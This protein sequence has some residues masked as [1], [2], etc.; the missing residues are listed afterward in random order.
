ME[1]P[2]PHP[3]PPRQ[4]AGNLPPPPRR[5]D[6]AAS[7]A[8]AAGAGVAAAAA[9]ALPGRDDGG[10]GAGVKAAPGRSGK[11][12]PAVADQS[13]DDLPPPVCLAGVPLP[14]LPSP[15]EVD[16]LDVHDASPADTRALPRTHPS[17]SSSCEA[18][19]SK[20]WSG[21]NDVDDLVAVPPDSEDG[22]TA[23]TSD[24]D[25][26]N[27]NRQN[28]GIK[29]PLN[30]FFVYKV[31]AQPH[32]ALAYPGLS[33]RII[34]KMISRDWNNQTDAVKD[35]FAQLA[36]WEKKK[37]YLR[38]PNYKYRPGRKVAKNRQSRKLAEKE[39]RA[40]G[41]KFSDEK[42]ASLSDKTNSCGNSPE[43]SGTTAVS[44]AAAGERGESPSYESNYP[45]AATD[46]VVEGSANR[47]PVRST[48]GI[49]ED[50]PGFASP[51]AVQRWE[52]ESAQ[53]QTLA[54]DDFSSWHRGGENICTDVAT[55]SAATLPRAPVK[56]RRRRGGCASMPH[57]RGSFGEV[58]TDESTT[59]GTSQSG[60]ERDSDL[61]DVMALADEESKT[62]EECD[63]EI[64]E[65]Q[66]RLERL[67]RLKTRKA[68]EKGILKCVPPRTCSSASASS[69]DGE[70]SSEAG[71][72]GATSS[73]SGKREAMHEELIRDLGSIFGLP[74]RDV[75][76]RTS[77]R[78]RKSNAAPRADF[79]PPA[80]QSAPALAS[81]PQDLYV[82]EPRAWNSQ[83]P[84]PI[85]G[86]APDAAVPSST[87]SFRRPFPAYPYS[88]SYES[89][90]GYSY[91]SFPPSIYS[92]SPLEYFPLDYGAAG[93]PFGGQ[94]HWHPQQQ[95]EN[96]Q[97]GWLPARTPPAEK[98]MDVEKSGPFPARD[99]LPGPVPQYLP[100]AS[101]RYLH[102]FPQHRRSDPFLPPP[103]HGATKAI[104]VSTDSATA[105]SEFD[106]RRHPFA[107]SYAVGVHPHRDDLRT[108][109]T[110]FT[111]MPVR[112]PY[113]Q[114]T[115]GDA[116][117]QPTL[118]VS[119][120]SRPPQAVRPAPVPQVPP[121]SLQQHHHPQPA[122]VAGAR[123]AESD[124]SAAD[125]LGPPPAPSD[126]F[127]ASGKFCG[128]RQEPRGA[129]RG[130]SAAAGEEAPVS[131]ENRQLP[132]F[133]PP[134]AADDQA[135]KSWQSSYHPQAGQ[136]HHSP[137]PLAGS[138]AGTAYRAGPYP[139]D[140]RYQYRRRGDHH[141]HGQ[142]PFSRD[143]RLPADGGIGGPVPVAPAFPA[144]DGP[145][146]ENVPP[147]APTGEFSH[148]IS[149][150]QKAIVPADEDT[151]SDR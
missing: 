76:R 146:Q 83:G 40:A 24:H 39:I 47:A 88:G 103:P 132:S 128:A 52:G 145:P 122:H 60:Y 94:V 101:G 104:S 44:V 62:V 7:P 74:S 15:E 22:L 117:A 131:L 136:L 92:H 38:Y 143:A 109:R 68:N 102:P 64:A 87:Y 149:L 30:R 9:A 23:D 19:G 6:A 41:A 34:S 137:L 4:C 107:S 71:E 85:P 63:E 42:L 91:C 14:P 115:L 1:G 125:Q 134:T 111:E 119:Q 2:L 32:Y 57:H 51:R 139:D 67:K 3:S 150:L 82:V 81:D 70:I 13:K 50:R 105:G 106:T 46:A 75:S 141:A 69:Q 73:Q 133:H 12:G 66:E 135:F 59:S 18:A 97:V 129:P 31:W 84:S 126:D 29:R 55:N 144:V 37:H 35:H 49:E 21:G 140:N 138:A 25:D 16:H 120:N 53:R 113:L 89:D 78:K 80:P 27:D 112:D 127:D 148:A 65:L 99:V 86:G 142:T 43:F 8:S 79:E 96:T 77:G 54:V 95:S 72:I 110:F 58:W 90:A 118:P 116:A 45:S 48:L 26:R 98:P 10:A 100:P 123:D 36:E 108:H 20:P 114:R 61:S 121:A 11:P 151:D 130:D 5:T 93:P 17:A 147:A 124:N 28:Q 56:P 33:N